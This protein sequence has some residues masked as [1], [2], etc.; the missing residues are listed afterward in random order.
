M[1]A[2]EQW[3]LDAAL[4]ALSSDGRSLT[5]SLRTRLAKIAELRARFEA[6]APAPRGELIYTHE[7]TEV[8]RLMLK[9]G[10]LPKLCFPNEPPREISG[11]AQASQAAERIARRTQ[12]LI[13]AAPQL[14]LFGPP[15]K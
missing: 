4:A 11:L 6:R 10:G 9:P 3:Q 8:A 15:R 5:R 7:E 13:D 2:S 1:D 12:E 14:G